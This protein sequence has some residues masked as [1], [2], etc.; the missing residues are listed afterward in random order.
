MQLTALTLA[1]KI[2]AAT[3]GSAIPDGAELAV[4]RVEAQ[5]LRWR[6][7]GVAPTATVGMLILPADQPYVYTG[8]LANIQLSAATAGCIVNISFYG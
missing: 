1:T 8:D 6:D 2:P 4:I 3:G 7:D 5:N